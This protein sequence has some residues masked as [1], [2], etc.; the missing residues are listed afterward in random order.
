MAE[1]LDRKP[2]HLRR[3]LYLVGADTDALE[4]ALVECGPSHP[5]ETLTPATAAATV[6]SAT[7]AAVV[8][9][10]GVDEAV[11]STLRTLDT[12]AMEYPIVVV[13]DDIDAAA[14]T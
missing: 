10:A 5:V 14:R 9:L 3:P 4:D 11:P 13:G 7:P 8:V 2:A 6:A 12:A 1:T